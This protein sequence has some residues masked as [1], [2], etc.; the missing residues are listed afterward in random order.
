[1][2]HVHPSIVLQ[3]GPARTHTLQY[4]KKKK[5]K[6]KHLQPV[7]H[8]DAKPMGS[9]IPT[10]SRGLTLSEP[11]LHAIGDLCSSGGRNLNTML[12]YFRRRYEINVQP[13]YDDSFFHLF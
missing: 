12:K 2:V 11:D 7:I 3:Y 5:K 9:N 13:S 4:K 6:K 8:M 1:M 10:D